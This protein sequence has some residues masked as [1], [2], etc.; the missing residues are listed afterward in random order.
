MSG[1]VLD[2]GILTW[3]HQDLWGSNAGF[4]PAWKEILGN[5]DH[6]CDFMGVP[7]PMVPLMRTN[8][9]ADP[10][11]PVG[12]C[13]SGATP[14]KARDMLAAMQT[15]LNSLET[16]KCDVAG[17][18]VSPGWCDADGTP[19]SGYDMT[20]LSTS[21][22]TTFG[23]IV[24]N[25]R[26][27]LDQHRY[28][29]VPEPPVII[30]AVVTHYYKAVYDSAPEFLWGTDPYYVDDPPFSLDDIRFLYPQMEIPDPIPW[31]PWVQYYAPGTPVLRILTEYHTPFERGVFVHPDWNRTSYSVEDAYPIYLPGQYNKHLATVDPKLGQ[32]IPV[33][34]WPEIGDVWQ[35]GAHPY[36]IYQ[37][38]GEPRSYSDIAWWNPGPGFTPEHNYGA[39]TGW[40]PDLEY[41]HAADWSIE[42][43]LHSYRPD[44]GPIHWNYDNTPK[45][46]HAGYLVV[47]Q[48]VH[49]SIH[50]EAYYHVTTT[51][52]TTRY[53]RCDTSLYE[54]KTVETKTFGPYY[55]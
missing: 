5:L 11:S 9:N 42:M 36:N 6:R 38:I 22:R 1:V 32:E 3:I 48:N 54:E 53:T 13:S 34:Y 16:K 8:P 55:P 45:I 14:G 39:T 37:P 19:Y 44:P 27:S 2:D 46:P 52:T 31:G 4:G 7:R 30:V 33:E 51:T 41:L 23:A 43:V 25:M 24:D 29:F 47:A 35:V 17:I 28:A 20:P 40:M 49:R 21:V 50:A 26:T 10:V 12:L 15:A 18:L